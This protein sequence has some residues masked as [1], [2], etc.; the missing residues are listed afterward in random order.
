MWYGK[1]LP[2]EDKSDNLSSFQ[3]K[4]VS[5]LEKMRRKIVLRWHFTVICI[6][7]ETFGGTNLLSGVEGSIASVDRFGAYNKLTVKITD[8]V[9]RQ[10]C[11][12]TL[13]TLEVRSFILF[14]IYN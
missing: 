11:Q 9:P 10:L 3:K 4:K 1:K 13:D 7:I 6:L 14:S 12:Q 8:Q 5:S 2:K